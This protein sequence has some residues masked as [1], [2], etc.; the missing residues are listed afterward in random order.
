M[1]KFR[2]AQSYY[3]NTAEARKRQRANLIPGNTWQKRRTQEFRVDCF[4]KYTNLE[5]KQM[6]Y[7][8]IE[9]GRDIEGVDKNEL[10]NEKYI[11]N[12][13]ENELILEER[14]NIYKEVISWQEPKV[15]SKILNYIGKCLKK[16][17]AELY[18]KPKRQGIGV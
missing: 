10:K 5:S 11:D 2:N 1:A 8:N 16:K 17:S 7:E 4:W 6:I 12:W 18:G 14:K 15:R 9:N 13:W 3:G